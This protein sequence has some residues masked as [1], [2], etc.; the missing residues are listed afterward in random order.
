[1]SDAESGRVWRHRRKD[2][3][4]ID[5]EVVW[6]PMVFRNRFAALTMV[7]DVTERRRN[8][9]RNQ[10]FSK[11]SH[12]LS[13]ATTAAEAATIICEAAD[14]LFEW[15]DF[16]LDLYSAETDEVFSLLNI[17]TVEE[18]RVKIP[19]SA[20]P[21]TANALIRRVI[22]KGA[23]L[24]RTPRPKGHATDA[25]LVPV[26]KGSRVIG[27]L[28]VQ[29]RLPGAYSE[30]IWK[31]SRPWPT[32]AAARWNAFAPRRQLRESQQ[33][34]RDLF[35]NSPDAIFVE[36]LNGTVLDVNLA[37]CLLHGL[38]REQLIGQKRLQRSGSGGAPGTGP[39]GF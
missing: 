36:D 2:G 4:V 18:R 27:V 21:K 10:V 7:T 33:R 3:S 22:G 20:Q 25:M 17:T 39:A 11:L 8:E 24:V 19:A 29:S 6:S 38:T 34:F 26:R 12:R 1:M 23:E 15:D 5:V 35:E 14:A 16:A 31:R 9:H 32:N 28:F 30:R 13:S 37:G